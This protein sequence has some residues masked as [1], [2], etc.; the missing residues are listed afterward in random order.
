MPITITSQRVDLAF[1]KANLSHIKA[2][3]RTLM[4]YYA[5]R[6]TIACSFRDIKDDCFGF[7]LENVRTRACDRRDQLLMIGAIA[8]ALL[9]LLGAACEAIGH[10]R[11]LKVNTSKKRTLS[12]VPQGLLLYAGLPNMPEERYYP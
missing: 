10:N 6:W 8:I 9:T 11:C 12:L 7:G 4:K 1:I 3:A 5:K 2:S